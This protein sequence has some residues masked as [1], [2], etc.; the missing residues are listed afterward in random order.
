MKNNNSNTVR[1]YLSEKP[2]PLKGKY[3]IFVEGQPS[4]IL[5]TNKKI[6]AILTIDQYKQF[7]SGDSIFFISPSDFN[8]LCGSNNYGYQGKRTDFQ[9]NN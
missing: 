6:R 4:G 1:V 5:V 2:A 8:L 7:L 9:I 3:E